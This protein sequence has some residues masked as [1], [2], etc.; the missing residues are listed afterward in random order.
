[1]VDT[2]RIEGTARDVGGKLEK[3][4]GDLTGDTKS[5]AEGLVDQATGAVQRGYG[6]ARDMASEYA[7]QAGDYAGELLEELEDQIES[8]PITAI[9]AALGVGFLLAL[10]TK[11]T[12]RYRRR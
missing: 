8:R 10:L 2:N 5:Q 9:M 4:V 3:G 12:P 7:G 11:P 1:M 6:Q